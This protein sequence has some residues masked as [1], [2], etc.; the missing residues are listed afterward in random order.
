MTSA[1]PAWIIAIPER[2]ASMPEMQT[3]L[4]VTAGTESG[5]PAKSAAM[6]VTFKVSTG[7]MQQ[8]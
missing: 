7:S 4:I 2:T 1:M 6:R 3:R 5:M 8:P